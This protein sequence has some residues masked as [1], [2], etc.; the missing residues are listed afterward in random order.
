MNKKTT[1]YRLYVFADLSVVSALSAIF[2]KD[3]FPPFQFRAAS[4]STPPFE[5][6]RDGLN[7]HVVESSARNSWEKSLSF[8]ELSLPDDWTLSQMGFDVQ[9][10]DLTWGVAGP[11]ER[12]G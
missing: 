11:L 5:P 10:T 7:C 8:S 2:Q 9:V 6:R 3:T 1:F 4:N 12:I